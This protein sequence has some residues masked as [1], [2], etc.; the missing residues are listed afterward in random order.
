MKWGRIL[1]PPNT[2]TIFFFWEKADPENLGKMNLAKFLNKHS[3]GKK[4]LQNI[5]F[6]YTYV[7]TYVYV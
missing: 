3:Y 5:P 1:L 7:L 6:A 4:G 2:P